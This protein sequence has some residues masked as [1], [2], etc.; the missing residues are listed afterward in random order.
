[1]FDNISAWITKNQD[2]VFVFAILSIVLTIFVPIPVVLIDLLLVISIALSV[3]ILLTVIY[4]REPIDFSAFPSV[5]LVSTC[6]RLALN[7]AT[8]RVILTNGREGIDAAGQVIRTFG[9]FVAGSEPLIGFVIF[10]II[11]I[12]NFVVIT[13]GSTRIS[14]VAARFTL[15]AMPG[16][17]M[18]IDADLNAGLIKEDEARKRRERITK[19]ADFYGAMDGATK[20]VRGDALAG[21]IITFI[22]IIGGFI[23]GA[24]KFG[25]PIEKSLY[26]YTILTIGDGLVSQIPALLVSLGAGLIVTRATATS[27][28]GREFMGQV[29]SERK[30]LLIAGAFL[31]FL[32]FTPLPPIQ[33]VFVG[34]SLFIIYT[35]LTRTAKQEAKQQE[36]KKRDEERKPEKVEGLLHVDPMELEVGYG[37][38]KLVDP[39]QQGVILD[40]ITKIRRQMALDL[41]VVVPPIRIRDNLQLEPSSY[42]VKIRGVSVGSGSVMMDYYL[43]MNPGTATAPLEEGIPTKEPAFGL[44]SYWISE[45]SK[46]RAEALGYT[47]V[48]ASTVLATHLTELIKRNA[49]DLL[50]REDVTTLVRSLRESHPN[51]VAEIIDKGAIGSGELQKVLQSLLSEGVSIR[52]LATVVETMADCKQTQITDTED[53]TEFVRNALARLICYSYME[54]DN[55][56]YCVT[57]DTKVEELIRSAVERHTRGTTLNL[58]PNVINRVAERIIQATESLIAQGHA[59]LVLCSGRVRPQVKKIANT[60]QPNI[61]VLS[62]NEIVKEVRVES[63]AI[64]SID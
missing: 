24:V 34:G 39:N 7:V 8:T 48:D 25:M 50:T 56:L 23:L 1:M 13:K 64:V 35:F 46:Q 61:T 16:K 49:S 29:F 14:E 10:L 40:K 12:I 27:N 59:P 33:L 3:L 42:V 47:V 38:I 41:G 22:N 45:S 60:L 63:L 31:T 26:T 17:Q 19:E 51:L 28:L 15:D 32:V 57:L 21:I 43:A 5:L 18:S 6:F 54:K 36:I 20:F 2:I 55:K 44:P 4:V 30:A 37:L 9:D 52:D 62:Y 11:T 58:A 53:M